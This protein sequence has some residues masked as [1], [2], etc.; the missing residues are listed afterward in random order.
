[1][2]RMTVIYQKTVKLTLK[3]LRTCESG[4]SGA[5]TGQ[6]LDEHKP[7]MKTNKQHKKRKIAKTTI[8]G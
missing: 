5:V 4:D 2:R 7:N 6:S 3:S 1:M 8:L